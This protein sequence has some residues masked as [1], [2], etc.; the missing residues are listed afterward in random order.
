MEI[1]L[2]ASGSWSEPGRRTRP[3]VRRCP[4]A[5]PSGDELLAEREHLVAPGFAPPELD[6][7][8]HLVGLDL[9]AVLAFREVL[10]EVVELPSVSLE[11]AVVEGSCEVSG[12]NWSILADQ[13]VA[14]AFQPSAQIARCPSISKYWRR[15]RVGSPAER[16]V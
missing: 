12:T 10:V 7:L 16:S 6:Q 1:G 13:C 14:T 11:V 9:G 8:R 2:A 4:R 3:A 5:S 15:L